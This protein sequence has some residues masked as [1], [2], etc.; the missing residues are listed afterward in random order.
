MLSTLK[1]L[2][3]KN[4]EKSQSFSDDP[5]WWPSGA[6]STNGSLSAL[7][8]NT[9]MTSSA[10]Y[11][12]SKAIA[13]NLASL[14]V[15]IYE[16]D[17]DRRNLVRDNPVLRML[18]LEPNPEIDAFA[19]WEL[20]FLRMVNRGNAFAV[21]ERD[22]D[23]I[24]IALWPVH[25]SRAVPY[26]SQ[27]LGLVWIVI[28]KDEAVAGEK[29]EAITVPD[30]DLLN[31]SY[32]GGNGILSPGVLSFADK[33]ITTDLSS[34]DYANKF[35]EQGGRPM[36]IVEHPGFIDDPAVRKIFRE[37]IN[38][39]LASKE[40][41]HKV[42]VL[43]EGATYKQIQVSPEDAQMIE[44]RKYSTIEIARFYGVPP[45]II[46]D[47]Q[48]FKFASVDAMI[49][50][51]VMTTLRPLAERVE[52]AINRQLFYKTTRRGREPL[53]GRE[54]DYELNLDQLLRGDP[55]TQAQTN[56]ILR[57]N[58][59]ITANEWRRELGRNPVDEEG[60]DS[61]ILPGGYLP[62]ANIM[63]Q[64]AQSTAVEFGGGSHLDTKNENEQTSTDQQ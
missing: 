20:M 17:G 27:D 36:G 5:R 14:P 41:W 53:F 38:S 32:F 55:I 19:F 29:P 54:W 22:E 43:W 49:R 40:S 11:A 42:G 51:F 6:S 60:A 39:I 47:Y 3:S 4:A 35:F 46:Q 45:A 25:N 44:S 21:I 31:I 64:N 62:L 16:I 63:R 61:L 13:E 33:T 34:G 18:S 48:D 15:E 23:G 8:T 30:S 9:A 58:G 24:P 28:I 7:L 10:V 2:F 12:C 26:R 57:Q 52:N 59:V 37:D 1:K 50:S 56:A